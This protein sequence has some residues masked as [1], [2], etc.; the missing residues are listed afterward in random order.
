MSTGVIYTPVLDCEICGDGAAMFTV[1]HM[2][3]WW[4]VCAKCRTFMGNLHY[5]LRVVMGVP[6]GGGEPCEN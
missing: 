3:Q 5:A 6:Y 4:H 2:R 1:L